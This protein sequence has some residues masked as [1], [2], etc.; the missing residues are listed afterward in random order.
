M[1]PPP[2]ESLDTSVYWRTNQ[3]GGWVHLLPPLTGKRLLCI[4]PHDAVVWML[5]RSCQQL[6]RIEDSSAFSTEPKLRLEVSRIGIDE[7]TDESSGSGNWDGLVVHDPQGLWLARSTLPQFSRLLASLPR[8]LNPSGFVYVA[9]ANRWSVFRI[10]RASPHAKGHSAQGVV[11]LGTIEQLLNRSGW[12]AH[13]RYPLLMS[14]S[15]IVQILGEQGYQSSKNS[16]RLQERAKELLLGPLGAQH[17]APSYAFLSLGPECELSV[18]DQVVQRVGRLRSP[19]AGEEPVL[20]EYLVLSG[21]KSV[22]TCGLPNEDGADVVAVLAGDSLSIERRRKETTTLRRLGEL[23]AA[24]T[25]RFPLVLDQFEAGS[26]QCFAMTR[27]P[28]VTL[29]QDSV[30]LEDVTD[31]AVD[32]LIQFHC[33]TSKRVLIDREFFGVHVQHIL[34]AARSRNPQLA[35]ALAEWVSPLQQVLVG[36][37][38]PLVWMHGDYKVENVMYEP[39]SRKLTGVIDWEHAIFPGLPLLDLIYL[40]IFNRLARG[41]H[42]LREIRKFCVEDD[43]TEVEKH[44]L[45][46][47]CAALDI[48]VVAVPALV[49]LFFAHH[50]GTRMHLSE[51]SDGWA[52]LSQLV[53][54]LKI[55]IIARS[56][57]AQMSS[58]ASQDT[59]SS[60]SA[61]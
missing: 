61:R 21:N 49:A 15:R 26:A 59:A 24:K 50:I 47:Y 6:T 39:R 34:Q 12:P 1:N 19:G 29:D 38:I 7:V 5:S 51:D 4:S 10:A 17:W 11:P 46:R 42:W 3:A 44:R 20:K 43:V 57:S 18:L 53:S 23:G 22:V 33:E 54:D 32:F 52:R 37:E 8:L 55:H 31:E 40:L 14:G 56:K 35:A 36:L 58:E 9:A 25:G 60:R 30:A 13:R 27:I 2:M 28:G 48:P 41:G 45:Q 16:E